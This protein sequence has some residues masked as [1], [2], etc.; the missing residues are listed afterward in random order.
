MISL[1]GPALKSRIRTTIGHDTACGQD[2]LQSRRKYNGLRSWPAREIVASCRHHDQSMLIGQVHGINQCLGRNTTHAHRQNMS[3]L[4]P[5][6][7]KALDQSSCCESHHP[8]RHSHRDDLGFR[9]ATDEVFESLPSRRRTYKLVAC[10]QTECSRAVPGVAEPFALRDPIPGVIG[11]LT[12]YKIPL[13]RLVE[14]ERQGRVVWIVTSVQ[15]RDANPFSVAAQLPRGGELAICL[16]Q[17]PCRSL[18]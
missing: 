6:V 9:S 5:G 11:R 18:A 12:L 2:T 7:L 3:V 8:V 1:H 17:I 10:Q 15:V 16:A 13:Q 14:V 4:L